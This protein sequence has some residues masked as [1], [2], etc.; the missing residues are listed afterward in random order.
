MNKWINVNDRLPEN[1]ERYKGR[2]QIDVIVCTQKGLVT[3]VRRYYNALW[4]NWEW[5]RIDN[6]V[7]AW[8][9]LPKAYKE[10]E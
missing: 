6:I 7:I 3:K 5:G 10:G 4:G 2:K 9:P 8:M 1:D